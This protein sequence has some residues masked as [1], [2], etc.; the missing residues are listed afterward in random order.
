MITWRNKNWFNYK[1]L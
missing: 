1:R